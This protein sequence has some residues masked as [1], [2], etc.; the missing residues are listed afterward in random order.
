[1]GRRLAHDGDDVLQGDVFLEPDGM[2]SKRLRQPN[3]D[4]VM[5]EVERRRHGPPQR[6]LEW[7]RL[8]LT[9]PIVDLERIKDQRP[10]LRSPDAETRNRAWAKFIASSDSAPYRT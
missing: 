1:M 2:V 5:A 6:R 7:G 10:E 9:I 8:V 4:V 3:R